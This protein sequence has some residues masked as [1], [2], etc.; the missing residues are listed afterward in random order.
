MKH[1]AICSKEVSGGALVCCPECAQKET[2]STVSVPA[3]TVDMLNRALDMAARYC[4]YEGVCP[5][6][7]INA[8]LAEWS[9]CTDCAYVLDGIDANIRGDR[10][11]CEACW[12][13]FFIE[14]AKQPR[15]RVCGCTTR[16]GCPEGCYWVE[17]DLCSRCAAEG[18][19]KRAE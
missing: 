10:L 11:K 5:A 4:G 3:A 17:L 7:T 13:K 12:K 1:C 14:E 19:P 6:C 16:L 15:C 9:E 2:P 8:I 18:E